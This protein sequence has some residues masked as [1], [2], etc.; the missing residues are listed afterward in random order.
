MYSCIKVETHEE[1]ALGKTEGVPVLSAHDPL[2]TS[3]TGSPAGDHDLSVPSKK[4]QGLAV[5]TSAV[6]PHNTAPI[7]SAYRFRQISGDNQP[8]HAISNNVHD[9]EKKI[10]TVDSI[11]VPSN[12]VVNTIGLANTAMTK[13]DI[14]DTTYLQPLSAFNTVVNGIAHV[15]PLV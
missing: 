1:P 3:G 14:I 2:V 4:G 13:L 5:S 9:A 6:R 7:A 15:S 11:P 8:I 12:I 10:L